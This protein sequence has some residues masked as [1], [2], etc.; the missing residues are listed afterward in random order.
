MVKFHQDLSER[1]VM[2]RYFQSLKLDTRT[3]HERLTR[4]CFN[5]YDR[6]MALV[7]IVRDAKV[8]TDHFIGV[9]R[10]SRTPWLNEAEFA[11]LI[12]DR[13]QNKGLGNL[14]LKI[15]VE[16]GRAEQLGRITALILPENVEMQA[17]AKKQGFT[18]HRD[19]EDNTVRA[20]IQ[21]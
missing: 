10:L 1:S 15:L 3:A 2:L 16:I 17:V 8:G 20:V 7:A 19:I 6:E 9:G 5:D 14:L 18:L 11:L 4:V 13:W 12:S 21:L